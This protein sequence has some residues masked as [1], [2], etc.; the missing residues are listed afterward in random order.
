MDALSILKKCSSLNNS[1]VLCEDPMSKLIEK[2]TAEEVESLNDVKFYHLNRNNLLNLLYNYDEIIKI[3]N[4]KNFS[5]FVHLTML[6]EENRYLINFSYKMDLITSINKVKENY[7][8]FKKIITSII[9]IRLIYNYRGLNIYNEKDEDLLKLIEDENK[10]FIN[11]NIKKF[12]QLINSKIS[13]EDLFCEI[14]YKVLKK[15]NFDYIIKIFDCLNLTSINFTKKMYERLLQLFDKG[16]VKYYQIINTNDLKNRNKIFFYYVLFKYILK[17]PFYISHIPFLDK[18]QKFFRKI[19]KSKKYNEVFS[20][21]DESLNAKIMYIFKALLDSDYYFMNLSN[22]LDTIQNSNQQIIVENNNN[23][24]NELIN[25]ENELEKIKY[26]I[27]STH[28]VTFKNNSSLNKNNLTEKNNNNK[29]ILEE[30]EEENNTEKPNFESN[31]M[32]QMFKLENGSFI[33]HTILEDKYNDK[34]TDGIL[35]C[36]KIINEKQH[37]SGKGNYYTDILSETE[38]PTNEIIKKD[39][40]F[41]IIFGDYQIEVSTYNSFIKGNDNKLIFLDKKT[42]KIVKEIEGYSFPLS[43]NG[44]A[45]LHNEILLCP[46]KKYNR[47]QKQGI[48]S[49]YF[50]FIQ[51]QYLTFFHE[52]KYFNVNCICN[53]LNHEKKDTNFVLIGGYSKDTSIRLYKINYNA[54]IKTMEVQ[55]IRDIF[56]IENNFFAIAKK[57][58]KYIRQSKKT[59]KIKIWSNKSI[60]LCSSF[61]LNKYLYFEE[62]ERLESF[63]EDYNDSEKFDRYLY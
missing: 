1:Q 14:I 37:L 11:N 48:I 47:E 28:V 40:K 56:I 12:K 60:Y 38:D 2:I 39:N 33:S 58:I 42:K 55:F 19:I 36:H 51:N 22:Y 15:G 16:F 26:E 44:M 54:L 25:L 7:K 61:N 41:N 21:L 52:I 3:K 18:T 24:N 43:T 6:I 46:Y 50:N 8:D 27:G 35:K 53:L 31:E 49:I 13:I 62:L 9:I 4:L 45:L 63:Y 10:K 17:N 20:N 32:R 5:N 34:T 59:G 57:P 29:Q 30:I 23:N